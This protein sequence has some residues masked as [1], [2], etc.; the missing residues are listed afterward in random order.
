MKKTFTVLGVVGLLLIGTAFT[1]QQQ[2]EQKKL[3]V[4]LTLQEWEEVL[5]VIEQ[6]QSP[7]QLVRKVQN[8]LVTPLQVQLQQEQENSTKKED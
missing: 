8:N 7:Y 1:V 4:E 6:S 2:E 5:Q 3:K